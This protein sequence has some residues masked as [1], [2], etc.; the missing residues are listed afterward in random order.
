MDFWG[1][2]YR[3]KGEVVTRQIAGEDLLIPIRGRLADMQRIFAMDPVAAHI[4]KQLDGVR[5]LEVIL[6][7]VVDTFDVEERRARSDC[8]SFIRQ[9]EES[10]LVE[11]A[12]GACA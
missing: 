11:C 10:G 4:W 6:R 5:T 8:E 7:S 3:V 2:V 12:R 1:H 9:L